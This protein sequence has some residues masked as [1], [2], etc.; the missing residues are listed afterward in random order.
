MSQLGFKV[1]ER[2]GGRKY[3]CK[4]QVECLL[5]ARGIARGRRLIVTHMRPSKKL[6]KAAWRSRCPVAC[7][8]DLFGDRWTLLVIR[9]L[10]LGRQR[11]KEFMASPEHIPTNILTDRLERLRMEGLVETVP[12]ADGSRYP[13]YRLT[14]KGEAAREVLAAMRDWGLKWLHGTRVMM[15][16][17]EVRPVV[18]SGGVAV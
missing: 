17:Q 3:A 4:K 12:A 6:A 14:T 1:A 5:I 11:F 2:V 13:A 15:K 18:N 16:P 7:S 10:S 8:L 9:D